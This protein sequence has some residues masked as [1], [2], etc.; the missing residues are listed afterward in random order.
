MLKTKNDLRDYITSEG[1]L[2]SFRD[3]ADNI[4][5]F[6]V[7]AELKAQYKAWVEL[8]DTVDSML[9]DELPDED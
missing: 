7:S 5:D 3:Y 9:E 1:G 4:D 8:F 2:G 6:D